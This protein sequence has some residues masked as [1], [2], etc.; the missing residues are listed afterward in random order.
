MQLSPTYRALLR[1]IPDLSWVYRFIPQLG[2]GRCP[3]IHGLTKTG[4]KIS[5][6][7][8]K[9]LIPFHIWVSDFEIVSRD[10][11]RIYTV[12]QS[13]CSCPEWKHRISKGKGYRNIP[14]FFKGYVNIC[15]HQVM[16]W[17]RMHDVSHFSEF[18]EIK[19]INLQDERLNEVLEQIPTL[20]EGLEIHR[21]EGD[22]GWERK[23]SI[24]FNYWK[25]FPYGKP[26]QKR[27]RLG[28]LLIDFD[29]AL[30]FCSN[31]SSFWHEFEELIHGINYLMK[32]CKFKFEQAIK[33]EWQEP[34]L[35]PTLEELEALLMDKCYGDEEWFE[36]MFPA[37]YKLLIQLRK[38]KEA[39]DSLFWSEPEPETEPEYPMGDLNNDYHQTYYSK[40]EEQSDMNEIEYPMAE[41][42]EE[43]KREESKPKKKWISLADLRAF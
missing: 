28:S 3:W 40:S 22:M 39:N 36:S 31:K 34:K 4:Q 20:P 10:R 5:R 26:E 19:T 18:V 14:R 41:Y 33:P 2:R 17:L 8:K 38:E 42:F 43:E 9:G 16:Q 24:Q 37:E 11:D 30:H 32:V 7:L 6:F 1:V 27:A 25:T 12:S 29:G 21:I 15:K 23:F 13:E 35:E